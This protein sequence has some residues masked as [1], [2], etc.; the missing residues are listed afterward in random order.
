[1]SGPDRF[2]SDP[3]RSQPL[4]E[5]AASTIDP[6]KLAAYRSAIA[7]R[8]LALPGADQSP[9]IDALRAALGAAQQAAATA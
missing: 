5:E 3:L 8:P 6:A 4:G 1:M 7:H 2:S 9:V